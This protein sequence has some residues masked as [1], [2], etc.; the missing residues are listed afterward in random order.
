MSEPLIQP[1][2]ESEPSRNG[3]PADLVPPASSADSPGEARETRETPTLPVE[4]AGQILRQRILGV[5]AALLVL[6]LPMIV[7]FW[8]L[9]RYTV[10][11][12]RVFTGPAK[13]VTCVAFSPDGSMIAAGSGDDT[14]RLWD[15]DSGTEIHKLSK[16]IG[17][18]SSLAFSPDGRHLAVGDAVT[19][20]LWNVDTGQEERR[21]EEKTNYVLCVAYSP[22]GKHLATAS[23]AKELHLFNNQAPPKD[24]PG[25]YKVR[26]WEADSGKQVREFQGHTAAVRSLAFSPDGQY[27]VSAGDTTL[28][29]WKVGTGALERAFEGHTAGV[30]C[31]VFA[32]SGK[33]IASAGHDRTIRLWQVETGTVER[34]CQGHAS[35]VVALAFTPDGRYLF[36]G[37]LGAER[38]A[39]EKDSALP[40]EKSTLRGWDVATAL[41]CFHFENMQT[42]VWSLAVSPDGRY[43]LSGG[44][45]KQVHL[46]RIPQ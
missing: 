7:V 37:S 13:L 17:P 42:P 15:R 3:P 27:L 33:H 12:V 14:V 19:T 21:L 10:A 8:L 23:A 24:P 18:V 4:D 1:S 39:E 20:R 22:D 29:L 26:L 41:E 16:H 25:E 34:T 28:R 11:E 32:P 44:T 46:W 36:S 9:A 5:T 30:T 2:P 40:R 31:V 6:L 45:D 35:A 38:K 43:L